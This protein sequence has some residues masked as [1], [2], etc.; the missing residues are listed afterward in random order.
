MG[1]RTLLNRSIALPKHDE[2]PSK[3]SKLVTFKSVRQSENTSPVSYGG[4]RRKKRESCH[5]DIAGISD[6]TRKSMP[7]RLEKLNSNHTEEESDQSLSSS[8]S[9][10]KKTSIFSSKSKNRYAEES[11]NG[12]RKQTTTHLDQIHPSL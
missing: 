12:F 10:M 1:N 4:L 7:V 3:F 6:L 9:L 8:V 11:G 2:I 5:L